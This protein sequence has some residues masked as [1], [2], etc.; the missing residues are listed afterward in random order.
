MLIQAKENV[1]PAVS[2]TLLPVADDPEVTVAGDAATLWVAVL[3]AES[4]ARFEDEPIPMQVRQ[5]STPLG[6][7]DVVFRTRWSDEGYESPIPREMWIDARGTTT[8]DLDESVVLYANAAE[9]LLTTVAV[10]T[11]SAIA[12]AEI[13]LG[14]DNTP[15]RLH[16]KYFQSFVPKSRQVPMPGRWVPVPATIKLIDAL[17]GHP[18]FERLFRAAHQYRLALDHWLPGQEMLALAH[19]FMG[20]EALVKV[21]L[22]RELVSR[23]CDE[24]ALASEWA[25]E[26]KDLDGYVRRSILFRGDEQRHRDAKQASDGFEHGFLSLPDIHTLAVSSRDATAGYLRAAIFDLARLD[27]DVQTFLLAPPYSVPQRAWMRRYLRGRF[28]GTVNDLAAPDQEYPIFRWSSNLKGFRR[29]GQAFEMTP[30]ENF[31]AVFAEGVVFH[32][33][34]FEVWGSSPGVQRLPER[35]D[36]HASSSNTT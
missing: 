15:G 16:R 27:L 10:A 22:R 21:A 28:E 7:I 19:L 11:N 8:E 12:P 31:T 32:Q 34:S 1:E 5:F 20:V 18:E 26:K 6:S 14:F 30:E 33:D 3:S 36:E 17:S 23:Q 24:D 2:V 35:P 4:V 9:A 25:V 13:K 29:D